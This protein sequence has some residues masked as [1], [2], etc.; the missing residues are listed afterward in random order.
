MNCGIV[1]TM[2]LRNTGKFRP[3]ASHLPIHSWIADQGIGRIEM[4]PL[5]R[6]LGC[7]YDIHIEPDV[8]MR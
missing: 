2:L 3:E 4:V 7:H 5:C 8:W 1:T 6:H